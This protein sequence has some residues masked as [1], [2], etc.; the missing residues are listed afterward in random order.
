MSVEENI[1]SYVRIRPVSETDERILE[2][3]DDKSVIISRTNEKFSF[4]MRSFTQDIPFLLVTF[5]SSQKRKTMI[6]F[7]FLK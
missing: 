5:T 2:K 7:P 6:D 4:G 1:I 3:I